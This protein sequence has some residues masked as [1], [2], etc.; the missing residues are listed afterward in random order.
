MEPKIAG[1]HRNTSGGHQNDATADT[2]D[3]KFVQYLQFVYFLDAF[4]CVL[5][6]TNA[7]SNP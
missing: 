3:Q 1:L 6:G 5:V 7:K 4:D 2:P